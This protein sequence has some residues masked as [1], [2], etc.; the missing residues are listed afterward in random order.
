MYVTLSLKNILKFVYFFVTRNITVCMYISSY[1][2]T[3]PHYVYLSLGTN[4]IPL[5]YKSLGV[6]ID[7]MEKFPRLHLHPVLQF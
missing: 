4:E 2:Y 6:D 3:Y 1:L 7:K 5:L